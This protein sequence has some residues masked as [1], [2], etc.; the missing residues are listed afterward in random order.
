LAGYHVLG[1]SYLEK[2]CHKCLSRFDGC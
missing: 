1:L 2:F